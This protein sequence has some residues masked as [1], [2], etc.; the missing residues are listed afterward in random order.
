MAG[1]ETKDAIVHEFSGK[2]ILVMLAFSFLLGGLVIMLVPN[3]GIKQNIESN[4]D[5]Y[6]SVRIDGVESDSVSAVV[7]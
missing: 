1:P 2:L 7:Q 3:Y 5:Y 6:P 4:K